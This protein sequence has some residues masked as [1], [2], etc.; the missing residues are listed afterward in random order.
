MLLVVQTYSDD[1]CWS[2]WRT[3]GVNFIQNGKFRE[4]LAS[5]HLKLFLFYLPLS[6]HPG[7]KIGTSNPYPGKKT[8]TLNLFHGT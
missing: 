2:Y 7:Q 8:G 4:I 3:P 5:N 1:S 6:L